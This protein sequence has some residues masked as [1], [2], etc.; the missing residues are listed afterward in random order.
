MVELK[1][2]LCE[3]NLNIFDVVINICL[4]CMRSLG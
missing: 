2:G 1:V 3:E 4:R